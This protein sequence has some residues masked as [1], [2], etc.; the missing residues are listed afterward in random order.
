MVESL[1]LGNWGNEKQPVHF[2]YWVWSLQI[3]SVRE[4]NKPS[5]EGQIT[6]KEA[7][8]SPE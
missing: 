2:D 4:I 8:Q 5:I 6:W 1:Q 3:F 7:Q